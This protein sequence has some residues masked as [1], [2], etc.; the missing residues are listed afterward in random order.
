ME[1]MSIWDT[2]TDIGT[3]V[4]PWSIQ[5][6][7][8]AQTLSQMYL[9]RLVTMPCFSRIGTKRVGGMIR[10]SAVHQRASDSAP[11]TRP[12]ETRHWGWRQKKISWL[13]RP[14]WKSER[15]WYSSVLR[16]WIS[17]S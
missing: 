12:V 1:K 15:I 2:F 10:P 14:R 16:R 13:S 7:S 9:S 11:T 5:L 6:R 8:Q 17:G 3:G 4:W